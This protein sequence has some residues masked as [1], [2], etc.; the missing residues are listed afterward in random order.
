MAKKHLQPN[1]ALISIY[2]TDNHSYVWAIPSEDEIKFSKSNMGAKKITRIANQLRNALAPDPE[3]LGDIPAFDIEQAYGL[4]RD[5]LKPVEAAWKE[6]KHLIIVARGP[7]GQLPFAILPT[8]AV[9]L[10]EN[11]VLF[12]NY[13]NVPWLIRKVSISRQPSVSS[14]ITLRNLPQGNPE[15]KAFAGFGD[16]FFNLQQLAHAETEKSTQKTP[17]A[18]LQKPLQVRG[19]RI[20]DDGN[21]DSETITSSHLGMLNRLPDTSDEILSI[22]EALDANPQKDVFVGNRAS[23]QKV[24]SMDLSDR[25]VIAFATHALVPGDLDG[26][27]Q[28]AL[29]LCSPEVTGENEDGLLTLGEILKLKLNADWVVLSACNTGAADGAGAEAVSGLGRAFFYAGTRAILVSM[30]PV[31]TT[32]ARQLTSRLFAY[33]K[34]DKT[35]SRAGALRQSILAL[36]DGAGMKNPVSGKIAASYAHPFFWAPFIIVGDSGNTVN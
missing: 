26:L 18:G 21:L 27:D 30:W 7:L 16:P 6:A 36:I 8:S 24:K 29:A 20:T 25:K 1:E 11:D 32:S 10:Q 31:E 4:Y 33:Q 9:K 3:T 15:R 19:I 12:A 5:L 35:L 23:E 34:Q 17:F 28:P 22:A 14:F 2:T 13:R